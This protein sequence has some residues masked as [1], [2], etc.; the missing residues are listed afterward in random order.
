MYCGL[1]SGECRE[2]VSHRQTA[3]Q[4]QSR[5]TEQ[6][7]KFARNS[8]LTLLYFQL[9][10]RRPNE[11]QSRITGKFLKVVKQFDSDPTVSFAKNMPRE[12]ILLSF[13]KLPAEPFLY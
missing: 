6:L 8:T 11:G 3:N 13:L 1:L 12:T 7:P 10:V 2:Y 5:I 4:G 9:N